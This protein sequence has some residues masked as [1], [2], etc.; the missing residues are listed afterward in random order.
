MNEDAGDGISKVQKLR[1]AA[2][3]FINMMLPRD[4]LGLV[5]FNPTATRLME[6]Q[7]VGPAPGGWDARRRSN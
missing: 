6:V 2:D 3:V 1:E 7:D 4:G 5:N